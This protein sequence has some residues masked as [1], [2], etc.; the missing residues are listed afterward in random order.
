MRRIF[1]F[2]FIFAISAVQ[3]CWSAT[4]QNTA[5]RWLTNYEE[6]VNQSKTQSKPLLLFFTGTGWCPACAK[7]EDEVFENPDFAD[8]A[9]NSFIFLKLDFPSDKSFIDA[10]TQ[11]QNK[12]LLRRYDVRSF[13][14]VILLDSQ[15]QQQIGTTGY[16]PGGARAYASHLFRMVDDY[17]K[18]NQNIQKV[19]RQV[20]TGH[21]LKQLYEKAKEL[22]LDNDLQKIVKAGVETDMKLYFQLEHYRILADEGMFHSAEAVALRQQLLTAD[23]KNEHKIPYEIAV[24][25]FEAFSEEKDHY[26]PERAV[27]PLIAYL[28]KYGKQDKENL[29]RLQMIISQVYL[30]KNRLPEALKFAKSSFE[31]APTTVQPEIGLAI[32]NIQAS[33][34]SSR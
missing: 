18:Y 17:A 27:A 31:S 24:I 13:P 12:Q 4:R 7:L 5:I 22:D 1:C 30:D 32:K 3:L 21:E 19:G 25:D 26:S 8:A 34:L 33:I 28:D 16:R 23:A 10:Q 2:L 15:R 11:A 20:V 9:G 14:T 6:A 29:W